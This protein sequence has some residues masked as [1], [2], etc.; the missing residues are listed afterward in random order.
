MDGQP[1]WKWAIQQPRPCSRG[2]AALRQSGSWGSLG[3]WG[4]G[5]G[6]G[7]GQGLAVNA[8]DGLFEFQLKGGGVLWANGAGQGLAAK[9]G[10][11]LEGAG[12]LAEGHV[13]DFAVA[14]AFEEALGGGEEFLGGGPLL[15]AK[16]AGAAGPVSGFLAAG[17]GLGLGLG[18][19]EAGVVGIKAVFPTE[20]AGPGLDGLEFFSQ[21]IGHG[22]KGAGVAELE[23]GH[24]GSEGAGGL[25]GEGGESGLRVES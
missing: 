1:T 21:V 20:S 24:E 3:E 5:R 23:E 17:F 25:A 8:L 22:L 11:D 9:A 18:F 4:G 19:Q 6:A 2:G 13:L 15:L 12:D 7:G 14:K 10:G 16:G